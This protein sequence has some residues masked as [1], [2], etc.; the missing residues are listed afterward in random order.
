M[1]YPSGLLNIN[2]FID[3]RLYGNLVLW[4]DIFDPLNN[5]GSFLTD[6]TVMSAW[7]DRSGNS[8]DFVQVTGSQ[9]PTY[10]VNVINLFDG[11]DDCFLS[12]VMAN[13]SSPYSFYFVVNPATTGGTNRFFVDTNSAAR[14]SVC[15]VQNS[16]NTGWFDGTIRNVQIA[17]TG[18]QQLS[19]MLGAGAGEI[20]RNGTLGGSSLYSNRAFAS[21]T[22]IGSGSDGASAFFSGHIGLVLVFNVKHDS[23]TRSKVMTDIGRIWRFARP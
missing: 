6:N 7:R 17:T 15:H 20:V 18:A 11:S 4:L 2:S 9:Q 3:F 1:I 14:L 10:K 16:A 23:T 8:N 5:G 21:T 19:Y 12:T 22:S 13:A